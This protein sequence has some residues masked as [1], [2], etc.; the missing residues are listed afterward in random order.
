MARRLSGQTAFDVNDITHIA[1]ILGVS[2]ADL[3]DPTAVSSQRV[4]S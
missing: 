2:A 1:E 4:A 3:L